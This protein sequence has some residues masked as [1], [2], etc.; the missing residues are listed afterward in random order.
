[1]TG[2]EKDV[3]GTAGAMKVVVGTPTI[4]ADMTGTA[5]AKNVVVATGAGAAMGGNKIPTSGR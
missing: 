1:V 4:G 2:T 5:G 3:T